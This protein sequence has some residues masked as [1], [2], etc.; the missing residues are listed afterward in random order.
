V[1]TT[2][3]QNADTPT[4]A[5]LAAHA[6]RKNKDIEALKKL[7]SKDIKEFLTMLGQADEKNKQTLDDMLREMCENP[8]AATAEA[9]NEK[10]NGDKATIEY[11]DEK[12]GWS[13]M[14]FVKEDGMWKL[15]IEKP[16]KG[17]IEIETS[18]NKNSNRK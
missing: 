7:F 15:T 10:I 1:S 6:A 2:A 3:G 12:G 13:R 16:E 9:R 17:D 18:P 8:Q 4:G 5:Y 11:L 14:D